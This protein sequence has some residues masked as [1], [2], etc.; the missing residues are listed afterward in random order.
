MPVQLEV[1]PAA[2]PQRRALEAPPLRRPLLP[3]GDWLIL[4]ARPTPNAQ[5][6]TSPL[7]VFPPRQEP[8]PVLTEGP[9]TESRAITVSQLLN[10]LGGILDSYPDLQDVVLLGEISGW[11]RQASSGHCYFCLKDGSAQI[12]CVLFKGRAWGLK[13]QPRDGMAVRLVGAV[14]VYPAKGELQVVVRGIVPHGQGSLHEQLE[15]LKKKLLAEGL[16]APERK[17]PLPRHPRV[18]GLV[19]SPE[20]AVLHDIQTTLRRRNPCV[21]IV[22]ARSAVQG[23]NADAQLVCALQ[24]LQREP[25]IDCIILARGGGSLEDLMAFNSEALVRAIA[26]CPLPVISAVGHE[27]DVTLCDH[28]ADHRAPT[29]T[30]A[31][32]IVAPDRTDLLRALHQARERLVR[33][34]TR[35]IAHERDRLKHLQARAPLRFPERLAQT[36]A[37]E[38][39]RLA[40]GLTRA[41]RQRLQRLRDGLQALQRL[42][43][44]RHP[45]TRVQ[46]NLQT[47][48][49]MRERLLRALVRRR[50]RE[51][52]AIHALQTR[53]QRAIHARADRERQGLDA[54]TAAPA[55]REPG[56]IVAGRRERLEGLRTSLLRCEARSR[57]DRQRRLQALHGRLTALS[58]LGVLERGYALVQDERGHVL[59]SA[60]EARPG[61]GLQVR[62]R[63]GRLVTRVEG[64]EADA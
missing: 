56:R 55:L 52:Q 7:G 38:L 2:A 13:F 35:R 62:L 42:A 30:A 40:D 36:R 43:R 34:L 61:Q 58:P 25:G 39:D 4:Q 17:R 46:H 20:G 3:S 47:L 6:P 8:P 59:L 15:A 18:V 50:E 57:G 53:L 28:V 26:E 27:T 51:P 60:H 37:Q 29:P 32:E 19:T 48:H 11:R 14:G 1:A 5:R 63:D 22:L 41:M 9:R 49:A 31:A 12:Q 23:P 45:Q 54:L 16:F 33:A 21:K 44:E 64:V 10:R 24:K